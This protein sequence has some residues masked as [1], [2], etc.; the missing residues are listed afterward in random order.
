[1]FRKALF[2]TDLSAA[3]FAMINCSC[4]EVLQ[5]LGTEECIL[6]MCIDGGTYNAA[7]FEQTRLV[8]EQWLEKQKVLLEKQGLKTR[9]QVCGESPAKGVPRLAE[10]KGCSYII[11]GSQGHGIAKDVLMGSVALEI[12]H[13][14]TVPVLLFHLKAAGDEVPENI[15]CCSL[16]DNVLGHVLFPTDFSSDADHAFEYLLEIAKKGANRITLL[17]IQEDRRIKPHLEHRLEEF[18]R[19]DTE[20]LE[21]MKKRIGDVAPAEVE[22]RL[23]QGSAVREILET[24]TLGLVSMIVM[25]TRGRSSLAGI[26]MGSVSHNVARNAKVPLLL[27]PALGKDANRLD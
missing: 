12:L 26:F 8:F 1:M 5:Q 2:A 17:H 18:N 7:V 20:R 22:I 11:L 6:G 10:S 13:N 4:L 9:I 16:T 27:V 24:A 15:H 19:I 14:A 25:G 21:V 23:A 3:S